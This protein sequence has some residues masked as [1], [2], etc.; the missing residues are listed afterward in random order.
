MNPFA[1]HQPRRHALAHA[2][3]EQLLKH[4]GSP[5]PPSLGKYAVVGN[6]IIYPIAQKPEV[7]QPLRNDLHQ[8][9][10]AG[11]VIEEEQKHHFQDYHRID[12][13]ISVLS[14]SVPN[15][16]PSEREVDGGGN[17][18][19]W[20]V[21]ADTA[22]QGDVVTEQLFLLILQSHHGG[23]RPISTAHIQNW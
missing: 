1:V 22:I 17:F 13:Y 8:F 9:P 14:V 2:T 19:K 3:Q 12:R 5:P 21:G 20:V 7:I 11:D 4:L 23:V 15:F 18:P 10:L 6:A 16:Q